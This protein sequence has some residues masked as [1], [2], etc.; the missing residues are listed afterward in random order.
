MDWLS[1]VEEKCGIKISKWEKFFSRRNEVYAVEGVGGNGRSV[2]YAVKIYCQEGIFQEPWIMG[3]LAAAGVKV[4]KLIWY[5]DYLMM[6]EFISGTVLADMME[7]D[8]VMKNK[9]PLWAKQLARWLYRLHSVKKFEDRYFSMPDLNLRNFIFDG[10]DFFGLDFEEL[11]FHQPE[12]DL[13]GL[14]AFILNSDPMFEPWK[15]DVVGHLIKSYDELRKIN[16]RAVEDYF[17]AEMEAAAKRRPEQRDCLKGK[18]AEMKAQKL[19]D[20]AL[21]RLIAP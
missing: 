17:Y 9:T 12:R 5:N 1:L 10:K 16:I 2:K 8:G 3:E 21:D 6:T 19:F 15:F 4:P 20:G 7:K 13:G 11:V 14:A 18:I